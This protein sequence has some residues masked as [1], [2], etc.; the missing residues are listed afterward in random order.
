MEL[1]I[2]W[3][4]LD[5]DEHRCFPLTVSVNQLQHIRDSG[6]GSK[7]LSKCNWERCHAIKTLLRANMQ[8][9]VAKITTQMLLVNQS[10]LKATAFTTILLN[11]TLWQG[12]NVLNGWKMSKYLKQRS[13]L[14]SPWL[15]YSCC[16]FT[17]KSL[18]Q[19]V[20]IWNVLIL[21]RVGQVRAPCCLTELI[22][23]VL[24][25]SV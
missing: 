5:V 17:V 21:L 12:L 15:S 19:M 1:N 8:G 18:A 9:F 16:H 7:I 24:Q 13:S 2:I 10:C 25:P 11:T 4:H 22:W 14:L 6:T 23:W 3:G 20:M